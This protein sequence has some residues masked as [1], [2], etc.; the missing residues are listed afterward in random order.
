MAESEAREAYALIFPGQG[1]Q[2]VGMGYELY[3][4]SAAAR[5][6]FDE[7]DAAAGFALSTLIFNGPQEQLTQTVNAQPAILTMSIAVLRALQETGKLP[8]GEAMASGPAFMAG[9]SLGEYTALVAAGSLSLSDAVRLVQRRGALMQSAGE[10]T[11]SGMAAVIGL[12]EDKLREVCREAGGIV[13]L[14]NINAPDQIVIS[15]EREALARASD[16]AKAAGA[17][18][19]VPLAVSG[20]FHSPVMEYAANAFAADVNAAPIQNATVPIIS[21]VTAQPIQDAAAIRKELVEQLTSPVNWVQSVNYML[22][23]GVTRYIELGPGTVLAGLVKRIAGNRPVKV[24][25]VNNEPG[26]QAFQL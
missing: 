21:N 18:R 17:R 26:V 16:L 3:T 9:H 6:V 20:A 1:A 8:A 24:E 25:S 19:V 14:A 4:V 5:A 7:A 22:D 2:T 12:A 23:H 10:H 11:Q 13:V 15:G